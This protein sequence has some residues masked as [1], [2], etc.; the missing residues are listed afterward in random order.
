[1]KTFL[2]KGKFFL[3]QI[4]AGHCK[5]INVISLKCDIYVF[6]LFFKCCN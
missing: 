2:T 4:I 3:C 5:N 6:K 1:M